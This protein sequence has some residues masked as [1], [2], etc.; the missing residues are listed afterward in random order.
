VGADEIDDLRI[1][2]GFFHDRQEAN[3]ERQPCGLPSS[4]IT[5]I[6]ISASSRFVEK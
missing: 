5:D 6:E 4:V 3:T 1:G 2:T